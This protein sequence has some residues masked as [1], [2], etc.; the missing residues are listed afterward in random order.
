[1]T[2]STTRRKLIL[3]AAASPFL[4]ACASTPTF[5]GKQSSALSSAQQR[6]AALEAA[7][8]GRLGVAA[9][10]PGAS[11]AGLYYRHEEQFPMCSTFKMLLA[12][13]ILQRSQQ[14]GGLLQQ[15]IRYAQG[16]LV[17]YS[18]VTEKHLADGMTISE[19]C[20]ATVQYSDNTAANLLL[21]TLGGPSAITVFARS[22][23]D[24]H[25]R[26]DRW[27]T[28]LN[29][30]I[31]GDPRDTTTPLAMASNLGRLVLGDV[32]AAPQRAQLQ[33]WLRGNTTGDT[34]IRA[35]VPAGWQVADKT[36]TGSY[37]STNDIGVL[38]PPAGAPI[39]LALYFTQKDKDA[40]SR[41]EVLAS[42][43]KIVVEAF[44]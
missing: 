22:L 40:N 28:E 27:E 25:T 36:G 29:S 43:T 3:L 20:A 26:L 19:L 16:E 1:M 33:N 8:G 37:G 10:Q 38:W 9:I 30:A 17:T 4:G 7:S 21:K 13:V 18:P 12:A 42:A 44:A 11:P 34:R 15:R 6:L 35:G 2:P 14:N 5:T 31:P 24:Q 32:L 41:S 23:G 39:A